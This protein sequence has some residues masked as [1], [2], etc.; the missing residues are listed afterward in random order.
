VFGEIAQLAIAIAPFETPVAS[1]FL[2]QAHELLTARGRPG[3]GRQ[4]GR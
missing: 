4:Q 1:E 2:D 3:A